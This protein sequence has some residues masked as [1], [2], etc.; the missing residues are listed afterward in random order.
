MYSVAYKYIYSYLENLLIRRAF[1]QYVNSTLLE[2][3]VE[4]PDDLKLGGQKKEITVM[5]SDIRGF[6]T[7]CEQLTPEQVI[8]ITN[9]YLDEVTEIILNNNGTV[10]KYIGDAVMAFWNAP[11]SDDNHRLNAVITA[12]EMQKQVISFNNKYKE[13]FPP[14]KIGIGLNTGEMVVGNVGSSKRFDYTLI[15]DE[16]NLGSR[17]EGLTKKYGVGIIATEAVVKG[18]NDDKIIFRLLDEVI[19]KG[20]YKPV[21]IYEPMV[22]CEVNIKVKECYE[23]GF[24]LYQK[25]EF[26]KAIKILDSI[27]DIDFPSRL[28]IDRIEEV[29]KIEK[30]DGVWKWTE[31]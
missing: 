18:I 20:K 2:K 14:I 28:I 10:D 6:T 29:K 5:F 7:I 27:S 21:I 17:I 8:E 30:W 19:V 25:G 4:N 12:I 16:V 31:K 26:S 23:R 11:I 15:G 3:I 22:T 24:R 1:G 9:L 13:K